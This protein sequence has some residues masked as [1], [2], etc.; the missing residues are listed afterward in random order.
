MKRTR[1]KSYAEHWI[2]IL[3]ALAILFWLFFMVG[4]GAGGTEETSLAPEEIVYNSPTTEEP[5][6]ESE[7]RDVMLEWLPNTEETLAGYKVFMREEHK[8][9]DYANPEWDTVD[10]KCTLYNLYNNTTYLFVVRAYDIEGNESGDS[11]EATLER[12]Y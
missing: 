8:G 5:I 12:R 6:I 2:L 1:Q 4:C 3:M 7:F 10:T 9:Y 11:N